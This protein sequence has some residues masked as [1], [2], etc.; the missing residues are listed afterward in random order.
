M[1]IYRDTSWTSFLIVHL[2]LLYAGGNEIVSRM[3]MYVTKTRCISRRRRCTV[4][5]ATH[6]LT[7]YRACSG[8][9]YT[10]L[11]FVFESGN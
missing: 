6:A 1:I 11:Q 5:F 8:E 7:F 3:I 4:I 2:S 9:T 10:A